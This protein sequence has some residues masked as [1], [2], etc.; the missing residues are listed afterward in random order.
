M[1]LPISGLWTLS[2]GRL[3]CHRRPPFSAEDPA[4]LMDQE[5][6]VHTGLSQVGPLDQTGVHVGY[7]YSV[8]DGILRWTH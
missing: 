8:D 6:Q 2:F 5:R 7:G 4:N 1:P 3:V